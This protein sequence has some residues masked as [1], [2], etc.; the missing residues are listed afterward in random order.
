[1]GDVRKLREAVE[2]ARGLLPTSDRC[3]IGDDHTILLWSGAALTCRISFDL[4]SDGMEPHHKEMVVGDL[5]D[6]FMARQALREMEPAAILRALEG[7]E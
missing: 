6:L 2:R 7:G 5:L 4:W 3:E 1:M